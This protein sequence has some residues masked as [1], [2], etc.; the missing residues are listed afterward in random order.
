MGSRIGEFSEELV[1]KAMTNVKHHE[2][3]NW[4]NEALGRNDKQLLEF[5]KNL[6]YTVDL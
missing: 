6:S 3:N 5:P 4:L 2:V 1:N